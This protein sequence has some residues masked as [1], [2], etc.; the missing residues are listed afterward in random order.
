M[1]TYPVSE[2]DRRA[3]PG[4]AVSIAVIVVGAVVA[5]VGLAGGVARVVHNLT[6]YS[7]VAPARFDVHLSAGTWQV[8]VDDDGVLADQLTPNDVRVVTANGVRVPTTWVPDGDVETRP[9]AGAV[10]TAEVRFVIASAG[11]YTVT[12][13]GARGT[14]VLIA[15]SYRDLIKAAI[16]WFILMGGGILIAALGVVLLIVGVVRR[17]PPHPAY[18]AGYPP[19]GYAPAGYGYPPGPYPAPTPPSP[20][21]P[22]AGWYVDPSQPDAVRWWDGTRWTDQ[23]RP[24][25]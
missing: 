5:I 17:R 14:A 9:H 3:G 8:W 23:T 24:S 18:P 19:A 15:K 7:A 6:A 16:G 1:T 12:V 2:P 20:P 25:P 11:E 21:L 10:Y 4:L 22:V 13:N